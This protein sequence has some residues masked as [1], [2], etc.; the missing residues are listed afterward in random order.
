MAIKTRVH[1]KRHWVFLANNA[2]ILQCDNQFIKSLILNGRYLKC[3]S[4]KEENYFLR[5]IVESQSEQQGRF[6]IELQIPRHDIAFI[7]ASVEGQKKDIGFA[8]ESS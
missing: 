3:L 8:I 2:S 7:V 5:V 6:A 1:G 4:A